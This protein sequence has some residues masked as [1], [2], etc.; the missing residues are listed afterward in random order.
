MIIVFTSKSQLWKNE[1]KIFCFPWTCGDPTRVPRTSAAVK[2][3]HRRVSYPN[4]YQLW[5]IGCYVSKSFPYCGSQHTKT[6]NQT[7]QDSI[8]RKQAGSSTQGGGKRNPSNEAGKQM[9]RRKTASSKDIQTSTKGDDHNQL[10]QFN[11]EKRVRQLWWALYSFW[12]VRLRSSLSFWKCIFKWLWSVAPLLRLLIPLL[13]QII[14]SK[15]QAFYCNGSRT[16]PPFVRSLETWKMIIQKRVKN[17]T[18]TTGTKLLSNSR[19]CHWC[20]NDY[21][22]KNS[23]QH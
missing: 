22:N 4:S 23:R 14:D 17:R 11:S 3:S 12:V 19:N 16:L 20:H 5:P 15:Q 13:K 9:E 6:I 10:I 2:I 21:W 7:Q 18:S 1:Q 8:T